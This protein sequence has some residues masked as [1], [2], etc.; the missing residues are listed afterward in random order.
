MQEGGASGVDA[1]LLRL[2]GR[3]PSLSAELLHRACGRENR[4]AEVLA[5]R[6]GIHT[7]GFDVR[8]QL[9]VAVFA[10][11]GGVAMRGWCG[12]EDTTL[13][14][15]GALLES[16]LSHMGP[17]LFGNSRS[18]SDGGT[19]TSRLNADRQM[20][21][22]RAAFSRG[23]V[24]AAMTRARRPLLRTRPRLGAADLALCPPPPR[25]PLGPGRSSRI[26]G[27]GQR[28]RCRSRPGAARQRGSPGCSPWF[29][30]ENGWSRGPVRARSPAR[31]SSG[32]RPR[33]GA[34]L[35]GACAAAAGRR[36]LKKR[37]DTA[38]A[39]GG[40]C[41][42]WP[43]RT[44]TDASPRAARGLRPR[45]PPSEDDPGEGTHSNRSSARTWGNGFSPG[46]ARDEL[47]HDNTGVDGIA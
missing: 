39:P 34:G 19:V 33:R 38:G 14:H 32:R 12:K 8:P 35:V 6:K 36:R 23:W 17:G 37:L 25:Q 27:R 15:I 18:G 43:P 9:M 28:R 20:K 10:A 5:E 29:G 22:R 45:A 26:Q 42:S 30:A 7:G 3:T 4:L 31:H 24:C 47:P 44:R 46:E 13:S 41:D 1:S 11:A 2:I 16:A 21:D 40:H